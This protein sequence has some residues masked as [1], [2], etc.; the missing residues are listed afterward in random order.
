MSY[1]GYKRPRPD[2]FALD[3][4][5]GPGQYGPPGNFGP[6]SGPGMEP[7]LPPVGLGLGVGPDGSFP[8]VK[9]RGLPFSCD[10]QEIKMFL[11]RGTLLMDKLG[12]L[13]CN[14]QCKEG[15]RMSGRAFSVY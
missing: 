6:P 3:F 11:V 12:R 8:L 2:D 14:Q 9:L 15:F 5:V 10:E 7:V 1:A 4:P 13:L